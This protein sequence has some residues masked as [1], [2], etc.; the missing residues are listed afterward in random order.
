VLSEVGVTGLSFGARLLA[1]V[2]A[3]MER[4]SRQLA[5]AVLAFVV[6]AVLLGFPVQV[7]GARA[8]GSV[9]TQAAGPVEV[10]GLRTETSRTVRNPDG[11]LTAQLYTEPINYKNPS[12]AWSPI[13][14]RLVASTAAGFAYEN[15]ANAFTT[16]FAR[17]PAGSFSEFETSGGRVSLSLLGVPQTALAAAANAVTAASSGELVYPDVEPGVNLA[18]HLTAVGVKESIVLK[19]ATAPASYSFLLQP[20]DGQQ[21][22]PKQEADGSWTF[23]AADGSVAF[24]LAAPSVSES[25]EPVLP[26][27]CSPAVGSAPPVCVGGPKLS[28]PPPP[29]PAPPAGIGAEDGAGAVISASGQGN[30]AVSTAGNGFRVTV[31]VDPAWLAS[32]K[33]VFPVVLDPTVVLSGGTDTDG[34]FTMDC[35]TCTPD[36]T[37]D[38]IKAGSDG[39]HTYDAVSKF[40]L[41]SIPASSKIVS[42]TLNATFDHCFPADGYP[43]PNVGCSWVYPWQHVTLDAHR[44]TSSWDSSTQSQNLGVDST[45]LGSQPFTLGYPGVGIGPGTELQWD[46]TQQVQK[47]NS[48]AQANYGIALVNSDTSCGSFSTSPCGVTLEDSRFA[49]TSLRP[50]LSV[51]YAPDLGVDSS[52]PMWSNGPLAVNEASGNLVV[53]LPAPSFP[54]AAGTL[55]VPITYNSLDTGTANHPLGAG[56][57][58]GP[59]RWLVDHSINSL[60]GSS[61]IEVFDGTHSSAVYT[62]I[63]GST[64]FQA[65]DGSNSQLTKNG[66]N[67]YTLVGG[68]GSVTTFAPADTTTGVAQATNVQTLASA[69]RKGELDY[70]FDL[71]GRLDW[72]KAMDGPTT[73]IATLAVNWNGVNGCSAMVC[74]VGPDGQIWTYSADASGRLQTVFDGTENVLKIT[75]NAAGYPQTIQNADDLNPPSGHNAAHDLALS[76]DSSN[77][78]ASVSEEH[79]SGQTPSTSTWSFGYHPDP[80]GTTTT[81]ATAATHG[82]T[83]AGT[84]RPAFGYTTVTPPC[85]QATGTCPGHSGTAQAKV[86][87]DDYGHPLEHVELPDATNTVRHTLEQYSPAGQLLWTEDEDGNPTDYSYDPTDGTLSSVTQP[88]PDGAGP[89]SRPVTSS[90]YDETAFGTSGSS[91][92]PGPALHGLQAYYYTTANWVSSSSNGRPDALQTD[93]SSGSFSFNWGAT[94]PP[95]LFSSGTNTG[96]SVRWVGDLTVATGASFEF[97]TVS[98]RGTELTIDGALLIN[99]LT[100]SFPSTQTSAPIT[101]AA[102]KHRLVLEYV[103][104]AGSPSSN[105]ALNYCD[106]TGSTCPA[107]SGSFA[108]IPA[109]W[110]TPAWGNK[111]STVSATGKVAFSH[112]PQPWTGLPDYSLDYAPVGGSTTPLIT[113]YTY[114]SF[115]RITGKVLPNGNTAATLSAGTLSGAGDPT[116]SNWGTSYSYYGDTETAA[117]PAPLTGNCLA[118]ATPPQLG[119]L[120]TVSQHGLAPITTI[121]DGAGRP[122]SIHKGAGTTVSCYDGEGRLLATKAPGDSQPTL[123]TYD[124]LGRQLTASHAG[125]S[126]DA[127]GTVSNSYDEAGRLV[128][129]T[130]ANGATATFSYDADGNRLSRSATPIVAS[131]SPLTETGNEIT[132]AT[133]TAGVQGDGRS[134]PDSSTGIWQATTNLEPNGGI[135]SNA[136]GWNQNSSATFSRDTS[137]AKFGAASLKVVMANT[138][139]SGVYG[140]N[141]TAAAGVPYSLSF[142]AKAATGTP[143]IDATVE[144]HKS[145]SSQISTSAVTVTLSTSWTRYT[146]TATSPA[147]TATAILTFYNNNSAVG[148][149]QTV[150][151]DGIQLEQ[152]PFTTP[153]VDTS[154]SAATRTAAGVGLPVGFLNGTQGWAAFRIRPG[155][156]SSSPSP[157][158]GGLYPRLL[159]AGNWGASTSSLLQLSWNTDSTSWQLSRNDAGSCACSATQTFIAGSP[160][161]VVAAWTATTLKLSVNGGAFVAAADSTHPDLSTLAP[162]I[163]RRFD[164]GGSYA[165]WID[166]DIL[167]AATGNGTLTDGDAA[168]INGFGN[169]DPSLTSFPGAAS[170][171]SVWDGTSTTLTTP[172]GTTY[173]TTYSYNDADQLT[174][175]TDPAG[176]AFS[177]RY[178]SRGNLQGPQ[179]PNSSYSLTETNPDGW[180]TAVCNDQGTLPASP[181]TT[182]SCPTGAT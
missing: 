53:S 122:V 14:S 44:V 170:T 43:D 38:H 58:I 41:S 70:H 19:G 99:N 90:N 128:S 166:A 181:P 64:V 104:N 154:G 141:I 139:R 16:R 164:G 161:T 69:A 72:V 102:G 3:R 48:L 105:L 103:E 159:F 32:A 106:L 180:T 50:Y 135:E 6:V 169:T 119:Q 29:P 4:L 15:A 91:Y 176:H 63:V 23:R 146:L 133:R 101:L 168:T 112:Y 88:D 109:N 60:P 177:Y 40:D 130:D 81:D 107:G 132:D 85:E 59:S 171:S 111:T 86:Y 134:A 143:N 96:Y 138:S 67:S 61:G 47:W 120:E 114:D 124:P 20:E 129:T 7:G 22:T 34:T 56:W 174:G 126:D 178:D 113:S 25:A 57:T 137:T 12:G 77:R 173:T 100:G 49:T 71:N 140:T 98:D 26:S 179:Y 123:F 74:F 156:G 13:D 110:L 2:V 155:F 97:A 182:G 33:R 144:W 68:D 66:D 175:E 8:A 82:S 62:A 165:R 147:L 83:T 151:V 21:L 167:W 89:L 76:Y 17:S 115:G 10:D 79:I 172:G 11:S 157:Y 152:N 142:W 131:T 35:A 153:Y 46:L 127:Q 94:G 28:T 158:G 95:A 118:A 163:G 31:S 78:A 54:T 160:Q 24:R 42:A 162:Q 73:T 149:A 18:Y 30:L 125:T 116:T 93:V 5:A 37:S 39:S 84:Q 1:R 148:P 27:Q 108:A 65:T 150:Y 55:T 45:V 117:T 52:W 87:Y 51:T 121:Y 136:T 145:D 80:Y 9:G 92:T 36:V 75:Y